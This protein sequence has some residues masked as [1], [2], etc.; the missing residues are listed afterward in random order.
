MIMKIREYCVRHEIVH[1]TNET[2]ENKRLSVGN[3]IK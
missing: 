3:Y 1:C 2:K